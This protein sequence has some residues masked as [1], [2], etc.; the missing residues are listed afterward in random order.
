M[1]RDEFGLP[2]FEHNKSNVGV[3]VSTEAVGVSGVKNSQGKEKQAEDKHTDTCKEPVKKS[4]ANVLKSDA[5]QAKF[6]YFPMAKGST[7]VQTPLEVL[8]NGNERFK[9]CAVGTFIKGHRS[10][11]VVSGFVD[12]FWKKD[13]CTFIFKFNSESSLNAFRAR[14]T[15]YI[16]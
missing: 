9:L 5:A 4:W 13:E 11:S 16:L 6:S 12:R 3:G 15:W 14:G 10:F 7:V 1:G 2:I 8:K